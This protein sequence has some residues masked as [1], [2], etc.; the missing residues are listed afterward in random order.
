MIT[1]EEV[2]GWFGVEYKLHGRKQIPSLDGRPDQIRLNSCDAITPTRCI[3]HH[4][5]E[6]PQ[7]QTLRLSLL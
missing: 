1:H 3:L 7:I 2:G 6:H 4:D 5:I